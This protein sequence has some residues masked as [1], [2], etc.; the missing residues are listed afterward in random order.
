MDDI[1]NQNHIL[2]ELDDEDKHHITDIFFR[3]ITPK[4]NRLGARLGTLNCEFAGNQYK[5][6]NIEFR[7]V[8]SNFDI[9]DFVYD[10]EC[11]GIDL[12]L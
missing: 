10:E 9:V 6:W 8:G 3:E 2:C 4:L 12:D 7:S 11:T 5:N 1:K